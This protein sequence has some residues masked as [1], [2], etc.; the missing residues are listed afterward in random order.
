MTLGYAFLWQVRYY[1][2][3]IG[4]VL[5][6]MLTMVGFQFLNQSEDKWLEAGTTMRQKKL[7][8]YIVSSP[9]R[10]TSCS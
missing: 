6:V 3:L 2:C 5:S 9:F 10:N 1:G 4:E 7:P 8:G